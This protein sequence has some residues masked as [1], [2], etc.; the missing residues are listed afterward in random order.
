MIL[1]GED[2]EEVDVDPF[3]SKPGNPPTGSFKTRN[4][5]II[6]CNN[7]EKAVYWYAD[8]NQPLYGDQPESEAPIVDATTRPTVPTEVPSNYR[9]KSS[10][11]EAISATGNDRILEVIAVA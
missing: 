3:P 6:L 11:F 10:A 7:P 9:S 8:A 1:Y 5:R 2:G 4:G